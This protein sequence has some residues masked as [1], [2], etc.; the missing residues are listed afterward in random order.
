MRKSGEEEDWKKKTRD[1]CGVY[2][3]DI[4]HWLSLSWELCLLS[5]YQERVT[6]T[7]S[8]HKGIR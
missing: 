1:T 7:S 4:S 5:V 6:L 8:C 2:V 3:T